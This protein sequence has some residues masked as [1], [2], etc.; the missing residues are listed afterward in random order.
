MLLLSSAYKGIVVGKWGN[1]REKRP[2]WRPRRRCEYNFRMGLKEV[3]WEV[4][5]WTH[6]THD[7]DKRRVVVNE[8]MNCR[9]WWNAGNSFTSRWNVT[10]ASRRAL[11]H[12]VS[13][14]VVVVVVV[15]AAAVSNASSIYSLQGFLTYW[16]TAKLLQAQLSAVVRHYC[17][18]MFR[19]TFWN[20]D[21]FKKKITRDILFWLCLMQQHTL[22]YYTCSFWG[23]LCLIFKRR[24]KSRL[25]FAGIIRSSPYSPR[26]QDKG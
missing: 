1:L 9:F 22:W 8:V 2:L 18:R 7:M 12:R 21:F 19:T 6:L 11:V 16:L 4:V 15:V 26:S 24:I 23:V 20:W 14:A 5:D 13:L 25:P 17:T 10:T 3:C